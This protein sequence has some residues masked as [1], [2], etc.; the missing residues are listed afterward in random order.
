MPG[1]ANTIIAFFTAGFWFKT[2]VLNLVLEYMIVQL[3]E[4]MVQ[5]YSCITTV[6]TLYT[7][8]DF[9]VFHF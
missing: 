8:V 5:L 3:Y 9:I 4:L 1:N 7:R 2:S 6:P